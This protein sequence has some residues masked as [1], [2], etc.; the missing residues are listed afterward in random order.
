MTPFRMKTINS[1]MGWVRVKAI[2]W[3]TDTD[4]DTGCHSDRH[5]VIVI[6][7]SIVRVTVTGINMVIDTTQP[8][9]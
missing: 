8:N 2:D 6:V 4:T 3:M 7:I 1:V 9:C 5:M